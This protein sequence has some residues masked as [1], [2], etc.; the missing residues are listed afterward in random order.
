M[1][2]VSK[3]ARRGQ[4]GRLGDEAPPAAASSNLTAKTYRDLNFKVPLHFRQRFKLEAVQRDMS[5]V[6]L[7]QAAFNYFVA[8]NPRD[9]HD[10]DE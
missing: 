3:P 2:E 5:Q 6:D 7:L 8:H 1:A 10:D 4:I 9:G